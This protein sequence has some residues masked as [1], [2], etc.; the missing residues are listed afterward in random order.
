MWSAIFNKTVWHS[1]K[2]HVSPAP[3]QGRLGNQT[4]VEQRFN[5]AR[6]QL[7]PPTGEAAF[8]PRGRFLWQE[9]TQHP[10][11]ESFSGPG[12]ERERQNQFSLP[13]RRI[14]LGG[15]IVV[16]VEVGNR[17]RDKYF[18]ASTF[19]VDG[20]NTYTSQYDIFTIGAG[21]LDVW[22]PVDF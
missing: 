4:A 6:S 14:R 10:G 7:S 2:C 20:G 16:V 8:T 13:G 17:G 11:D 19:V 21:Y 12:S 9:H 22:R 18:P 3:P 5:A 15:R 1:S